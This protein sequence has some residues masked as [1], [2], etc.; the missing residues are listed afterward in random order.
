MA[1]NKGF[2]SALRNVISELKAPKSQNNSFG[3]YKYRNAEDILEAVKPLLTKNGLRLKLSDEIVSLD[4]RFYVRASVTVRGWGEEDTAT[5]YARE[6]EAKK[7][8]DVAQIT[9]AASSYA[10]KYALNGMFDIDD[11][12]DADSQDNTKM[13]DKEDVTMEQKQKIKELLVKSG[14]DV[15][16]MQIELKNKFNIPVGSTFSKAKADEIIKALES[17]EPF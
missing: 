9:G 10:R 1:E 16:Y 4:G 13:P 7:G 11:T 2:E 3:K 17:E 5:A 8:M 6:D 15:A 14:V 12:K